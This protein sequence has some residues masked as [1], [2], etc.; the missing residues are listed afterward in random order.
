MSV[1]AAQGFV[2]AGIHCGI[3]PSGAADLSLVA[4]ADGQPVAAA[5]T[6]TQNLACAGPVRVSRAHLAATQAIVLARYEDD[7][8]DAAPA[9]ARKPS[10]GRL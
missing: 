1:T 4:T 10:A 8:V 5:A 6:F 7:V 2:A 3:K 9:R